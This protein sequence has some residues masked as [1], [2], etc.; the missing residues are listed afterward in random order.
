[1]MMMMIDDDDGSILYSKAH[2]KDIQLSM[3]HLTT[4]GQITAE[5]WD[6]RLKQ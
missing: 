3:Y 5:R 1:M 6:K 4:S 2:F